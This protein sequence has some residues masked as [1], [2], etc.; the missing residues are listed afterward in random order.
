MSDCSHFDSLAPEFLE[1]AIFL[2][3]VSVILQSDAMFI[4]TCVHPQSENA[5]IWI[6]IYAYIKVITSHS[7]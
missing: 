6:L 4:L 5:W 2:M 3:P 7:D 1:Y